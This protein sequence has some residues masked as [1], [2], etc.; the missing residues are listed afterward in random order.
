MSNF[1]REVIFPAKPKVEVV[2]YIPETDYR[3]MTIFDTVWCTPKKQW[4][5]LM[6]CID[7]DIGNKTLREILEDD[8]GC[9]KCRSAGKRK[10]ELSV[11]AVPASDRSAD[12]EYT[13]ARQ[14]HAGTIVAVCVLP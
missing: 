3:G 13:A 6:E 2:S 8:Q 1:F 7:C 11:L 14:V 9:E 10:T 12:D 4:I 5:S